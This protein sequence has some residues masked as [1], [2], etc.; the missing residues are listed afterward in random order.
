MSSLWLGACASP[1]AGLFPPAEDEPTVAIWLVSHGWHAGI[2]LER[3]AIP[4]GLLPEQA[5]FP[6]VRYLEI[7]WGDRAYYM[8]PDPH[9]GILLKAGLWPTASVL[10]V[11]GFSEPV[12]KTFPHSEVIRI[13]LG[14]QGFAS[15]CRHLDNRFA[16]DNGSAAALQPG[17]YGQSR[18]YLSR[19]S[20][21]LFNTCN[22]WTARALR[23][24]GCPVIP[25]FNISVESLLDHVE[26]ACGTK[27]GTKE[28]S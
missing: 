6:G 20:Y 11:V 23:T 14:G 17:L 15:L 1:P 2:V 8:H 16:R 25:A 24:A 21:H 13:D 12:N 27:T 10:H 7:G 22:V 5:D 28:D 9:W 19:D 3:A 26:S 18:F 4:P